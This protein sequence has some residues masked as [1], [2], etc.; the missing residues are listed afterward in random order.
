MQ[1]EWATAGE[2]LSTDWATTGGSFY[3]TVT[4]TCRLGLACTGN[5]VAIRGQ[6]EL[7]LT[8]AARPRWFSTHHSKIYER[9]K[10]L[11]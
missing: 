10:I 8:E 7:H 2:K 6:T 11:E 5:R 1:N 9:N 4:D 3:N